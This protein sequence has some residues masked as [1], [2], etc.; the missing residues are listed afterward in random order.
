MQITSL[1]DI[2]DGR[3]L[4][5]PSISFIY[6]IKTNARKVKEGD[7]FI[8]QNKEE[9]KEALENGAFALIIDENVEVI[10]NEIA[11]IKVNNLNEA[12]TKLIRF[13]LSNKKLTAFYCNSVSY[14]L[15]EILKK[16][17]T[18]NHI[19]LIPKKLSK[20]FKFIDD[21]EDN[22]TIIC[23][24]Q[25]TLENI[26][27]V[28]FDF[29]TKQY[30][31]KN[32]IE[33]SIFETTFSYQDRYFSKIKIP[34]LYLKEFLDVYSFLGFDA[35]LNKL[36]KFNKLRPIFVDKLINHTDYGRTDKFLIAQE[37]KELIEEEI[38]YLKNKYKY[39]KIL[40]FS[41][42]E[43]LYTENIEYIHLTSL[44]NLKAF[45]KKNSFNAA[46]FVG[47][48]HDTLYEQV[49]KE[50]NSPTLI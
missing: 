34:S 21:I 3:L 50:N 36:K 20:F 22:D 1:L 28:N 6:S 18:H 48:D 29:N 10:D 45:L 37:N 9:I 35:D 12:I 44:H 47:L 40:Y 17:T 2:V 23:S 5:Q 41:F 49:S 16:S 7:L 38:K 32:L 26:Y 46:Y 14:D 24:C 42:E 30:E 39:A 8:V 19:K 4:N 31:I 43:E 27:P 33:H 25:K 13:Q 11:W 15:F